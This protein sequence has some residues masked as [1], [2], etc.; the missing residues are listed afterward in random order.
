MHSGMFDTWMPL[1]RD[2]GTMTL[3]YLLTPAIDY[4]R[5]GYPLVERISATIDTVKDM[6][7]DHW[8]TSAASICRTA[9][10]RSRARCSQPELADTYERVLREAE[11]AG[12]D[13][14][15]QIEKAR[16][17][18]SQGFVAEAIDTFCRTQ[19]VMDTTGERHRGV[20]T[21]QDMASWQATVEAP[22]HYDY[23]RYR[24]M[25]AAPWTQG[26]GDAATLALLRVTTS[27]GSSPTDPDFIHLQ[28]EATKLA[29]AD[30]DTFYGDPKF[31]K[32][33][34]DVLLSDAYNAERRKLITNPAYA[35][36]AS[37]HHSELRPTVGSP[38]PELETAA[39]RCHSARHFE[40]SAEPGMVPGRCSNDARSVISLRRSAL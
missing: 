5:N 18:W 11:S 6:F 28:I 17:V 26:P 40:P 3:A 15:A 16:K 27:T 21:G 1:L 30:R 29:F 10:C 12:G 32:V 7:R 39:R 37:R 4:A 9:R 36:I 33:P 23:G 31:V 25:K 24:V 14:V 34:V 20:L 38:A 22:I 2:Y 13:R 19:E 35:G 8:T